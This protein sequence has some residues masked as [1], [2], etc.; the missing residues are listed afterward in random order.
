M[1]RIAGLLA[2]NDISKDFDTSNTDISKNDHLVNHDLA[3]R[4]GANPQF[5]V[6]AFVL[7]CPEMDRMIFCS[8][9]IGKV[10]NYFKKSLEKVTAISKNSIEKVANLGYNKFAREWEVRCNVKTEN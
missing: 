4:T 6:N 3:N 10:C 2:P 7:P 1:S 8:Y 5:Q 9:I